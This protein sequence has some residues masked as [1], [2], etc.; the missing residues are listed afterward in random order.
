MKKKTICLLLAIAFILSICAV[1]LAAL[2]ANDVSAE[3]SSV[4]GKV[5]V[6]RASSEKSI[7]AF[8]GMKLKQGDVVTTAKGAETVVDISTDMSIKA[9][10]DSSFKIT[11]LSASDTG[12]TLIKGTVFNQ[13]RSKSASNNVSVQ[14]GNTVVGVRGTTYIVSLRGNED[15]GATIV[16]ALE[17]TVFLD[18]VRKRLEADDNASLI[19]DQLEVGAG[20]GAGSD[21]VYKFSIDDLL[22]DELQYITEHPDEFDSDIVDDAQK[23]LD[24]LPADEVADDGDDEIRYLPEQPSGPSGSSGSSGP[25]TTYY[26]VTFV[27]NAWDGHS[28]YYSPG[29]TRRVEAG[30]TIPSSQ[31]PP[32]VRMGSSFIGWS[33]AEPDGLDPYVQFIPDTTPVT[34]DILLYPWFERN[35]DIN[36]GGN[37][38]PWEE[39]GN[40]HPFRITKANFP[41]FRY[42]VH[43]AIWSLDCDYLLTEDIDCNDYTL[44]GPYGWDWDWTPIGDE[45]APFTG[46][47]D[48]D[49]HAISNF[50]C[51]V[52]TGDDSNYV[53][54]FG[55]ID[56]NFSV[57]GYIAVVENLKLSGSISFTLGGIYA[58][59]L[60]IGGIAGS[61]SDTEISQCSTDVSI[62]A[63]NAGPIYMGGIA[64]GAVIGTTGGFGN[65]EKCFSYGSLSATCTAGSVGETV[66]VGG[67]VG[68]CSHDGDGAFIE[69]CYSTSSITANADPTYVDAYV[70]GIVGCAGEYTTNCNV[71][72]CYYAGGAISAFANG[73]AYAGGIAGFIY[74]STSVSNC[75]AYGGTV[76][77]TGNP[78]CGRIWGG[79]DGGGLSGGFINYG[80]V[81]ILFGYYT[82]NIS[83]KDG[84]TVSTAETGVLAWWRGESP[85][86][87]TTWDPSEWDI[88]DI[89]SPS[90]SIWVFSSGFPPTLRWQLP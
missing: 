78:F 71:E 37:G 69:N 31:F 28:S 50:S 18:N 27:D 59:P 77:F 79:E 19:H 76:S 32:A 70:G 64:G 83:D 12:F 89:S 45:S 85:Y 24:S 43:S 41:H 56:G 39:G 53:G 74:Q 35:D 88:Y 11:T 87:S 14:T 51:T 55:R 73:N 16:R 22:P 46:S 57:S 13:V 23:T 80:D 6:K 21:G 58:K 54:F 82:S 34:G 8:V 36:V 63:S 49:G 84:Q 72:Y 26:T 65:I 67:I 81:N 3:I 30:N 47:F 61:I 75:V 44:G 29:G 52:A 20:E 66:C 48:G 25:S 40:G 15:D 1:P 33:V 10:T 60:Y 90:T 5:T 86:N 38:L 2:A 4:K 17:G 7:N 68:Y 42:M 9:L 62:T